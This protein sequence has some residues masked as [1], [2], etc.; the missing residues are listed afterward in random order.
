V[1]EFVELAF[2]EVG[3]DYKDYVIV[4]KQFYRPVDINVL[5]GDATKVKKVLGWSPETSFEELVQIMMRAEVA[6]S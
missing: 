1:R 5:C 6:E 4:D 3:L 2:K